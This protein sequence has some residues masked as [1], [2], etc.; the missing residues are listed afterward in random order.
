MTDATVAAGEQLVYEFDVAS[1][2]RALPFYLSLGFSLL[3]S[4]DEF[5]VL[6]WGE[7]QL[8]LSNA[9]E[10]ITGPTRGNLRVLVDDVDARYQHALTFEAR[11]VR[12]IADMPYGLRDFV[13]E[14]PD[15]NR[16][17]FATRLGTAG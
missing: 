1:V 11:I 3:R 14:D 12:G 8:F 15:G 6:G 13:C 5:A 2:A 16:L 10:P 7:A 4:T 9:H 17:R